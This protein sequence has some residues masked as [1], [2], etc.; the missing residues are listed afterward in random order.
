MN[1]WRTDPQKLIKNDD[2]SE[3]EYVLLNEWKPKPVAVRL[4]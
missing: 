1:L 4:A 2:P 3:F